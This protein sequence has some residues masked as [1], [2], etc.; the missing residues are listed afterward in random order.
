VDVLRAKTL[1]LRQTKPLSLARSEN[2][3]LNR[4]E[5]L[6]GAETLKSRPRRLVL[7]LTSACNL[8]CLICGRRAAEFRPSFFDPA[9]LNLFEGEVPW[10]EEATLMGWGEP[11]IHPQFPRFLI[12]AYE[13]GL[14]K[15]FCTNGMRLKELEDDLFATE[16]DIVAV[17]LDGAD[18]TICEDIRLGVDFGRIIHSLEKITSR[19]AR[20]NS[21]PYI[22]FVFTAMNR[23]FRE[24][25]ALVRLAAELGL[26]EVKAVYF[27]A[28][29]EKLLPETLL[30]RR[31]EVAESFSLAEMTAAQLG[32]S[33]KLPHLEGDDPAGGAPHKPCYTAWRDLFLGSDGRFR[34]C[35]STARQFFPIAPGLSFEKIWNS[36]EYR[37]HRGTVNQDG[38]DEHC[39]LCYQSSYANWN[40]AHAFD[41]TGRNFGPRWSDIGPWK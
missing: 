13:R 37:E 11:T 35:M 39:R 10:I 20:R 30:G 5:A 24:L 1:D 12:W 2:S 23:N 40:Q 9:W 6:A 14:R 38:M 7:E 22:N 16:T 4:S 41:Q 3:E 29:D 28:F 36:P 25:P 21:G 31:K 8:R 34:P 26:E 15:Y 19:K 32:V 33:L 17:S 27:T 18:K